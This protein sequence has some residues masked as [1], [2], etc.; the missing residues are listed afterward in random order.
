MGEKGFGGLPANVE[1]ERAVLGA[2]LID[3]DALPAGSGLKASDFYRE[4][5]A[6][7]FEAM[8]ALTSRRDPIDY[9]LLC[10]ELERM[11]KLDFVG[12]PV[13][14]TD[15]ISSTV[16]S[17]YVEHYAELV[18]FAAAQRRLIAAGGEVVKAAYEA[19]IDGGVEKLIADATAPV[20][21]ADL[22]AGAKSTMVTVGTVVGQVLDRADEIARG[23]G[24]YRSIPTG[25][26]MLDQ[27]LNGGFGRGNLIMLAAR[28]AM[29]KTALALTLA[30]YA[31]KIGARVGF[32]SLEMGREE[33]VERLLAMETG[34]DST[35]LRMGQV[36]DDEWQLLLAAANTYARR[37]LLIDD[38]SILT[39]QEMRMKAMRMHAEHGLDIIFVDY[40]QLMSVSRTGHSGFE[41][42]QQEVSALSRGLKGLARELK[43]PIVALSQLSR[44]VES[45]SDKRPMLSDLRESGCLTGD[46]LVLMSDYTVAPIKQLIGRH[47]LSVV[48]LDVPSGQFV[49]AD[50][51]AAFSTGV[52]AVYRLSLAGGLSVRAT[53]NHPFLTIDGWKPLSDLQVGQSI[54]AYGVLAVWRTIVAIEPDGEEEVFDLTVPGPHNFVANG[55][56]AHNSIE[57]DADAV[58]FIYREDYYVEDTDRQNIADVIVAKHRHGATGTASLFFRKEL[59]Q[60]RDMEIMRTDLE[61]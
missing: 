26:R 46:S 47:D 7:I 48:A 2:L 60:F 24:D 3:P 44:A 52:K 36:H 43:V 41:N 18:L 58:M 25:F 35:R 29:G 19:S 45:R 39:L 1:A 51:S 20:F 15:L 31:A 11:G 59:S 10:D 56:V 23:L 53:A 49:S 14:L 34:I 4:T 55:I 27:I 40:L 33:L 16:S 30:D 12:G 61:Y 54:A 28:P 17:A 50:V 37:P 38:S 5:H 8:Q 13:F 57:Q 9:T 32:F 6:V 42:R 21:A 22:L